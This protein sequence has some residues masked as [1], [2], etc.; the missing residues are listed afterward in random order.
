MYDEAGSRSGSNRAQQKGAVSLQ[1][2]FNHSY[3]DRK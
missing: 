1:N 3:C 2:L